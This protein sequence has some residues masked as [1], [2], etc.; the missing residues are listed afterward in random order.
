MPHS[1]LLAPLLGLLLF[2]TACDPAEGRLILDDDDTAGVELGIDDSAIVDGEVLATY[3]AR[4]FVLNYGGNVSWSV[5]GGQLPP[6]LSLDSTGTLEGTP[7][8]LGSYSFDVLVTDMT[9]D[10]LAGTVALDIVPGDAD[11]RPGFTRDQLTSLSEDKGLMYDPWLRLAGAGIEEMHAYTL[12][13]GLYG[14]GPNGDHEA[15]AWD[16]VRV[17]DL[18][19]DEV[20][21]TL[22]D[23]EA[24]ESQPIDNSPLTYV[25]GARFEA[26]E[27]T[28]E[29]WVTLSHPDYEDSGVRIIVTAPDWCPLGEHD[30]GA[31]NPGYCL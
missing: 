13:L 23:W 24:V 27:D 4:L 10:D 17:G 20:E 9:V 5:T 18:A 8:Y 19:A 3:S 7:T 31:W 21:I 30:G 2:S 11:L 1:R 16:D 6:G 22:E 14:P 28:G 26:G 25:G 29:G 12:D 15:G